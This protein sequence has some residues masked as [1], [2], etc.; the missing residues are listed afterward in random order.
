[1][2]A[3]SRSPAVG[4]YGKLPSRGDFGSYEDRIGD[5]IEARVS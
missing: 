2:S 4:Y 1:M 3:G 5:S